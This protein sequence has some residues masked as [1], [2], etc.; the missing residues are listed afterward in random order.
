MLFIWAFSLFIFLSLDKCLS[1]LFLFPKDQLLVSLIFGVFFSLHL[2]ISVMIF[3]SFLILTLGS[4]SSSFPTSFRCK[5]RLLTWVLNCWIAIK[6]PLNTAFVEFS[7]T[8]KV[9]LKILQARLQKYVN[10][11]LPDV[12]AGFRKGRRTNCQHPLDHRKKQ[13]SSRKKHLL[14]LYWLHQSLWSQHTVGNSSRDGNTRP[15]YLPPEK[16]VCRSKSNS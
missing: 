1:I 15:P 13:K 3:I 8:S 7:C 4:V 10:W 12:L 9:M 2:F 11:E 6:F 16:S 5:F 14:L